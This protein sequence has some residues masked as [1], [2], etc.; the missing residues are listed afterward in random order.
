MAFSGSDARNPICVKDPNTRKIAAVCC[1]K[2]DDPNGPEGTCFRR[3]DAVHGETYGTNANCLEHNGQGGAWKRGSDPL[4]TWE[5][6]ALACLDVGAE[7]C[8][9]DAG[10]EYTNH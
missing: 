5:N 7:L 4:M 2:A 6:A 8:T 1:R 9:A 10:A 3:T